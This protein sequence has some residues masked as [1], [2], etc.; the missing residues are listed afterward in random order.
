MVIK[1]LA[2]NAKRQLES[3]TQHPFRHA[4]VHEL[5]AACFGFKSQA[6]LSTDHVLVVFDA[7]LAPSPECL[8]T[9]Q[10]RL[11][12]LGYSSVA[13]TAGTALLQL[14]H[15]LRLGAVPIEAVVRE[16]SGEEWADADWEADD[17]GNPSQ[18]GIDW[19]RIGL[20]ADSLVIAAQRNHAQAH[21]ALA[22]LYRGD[23]LEETEGSEYWHSQMLQGRQLTGIELEWAMA[24]RQQVSDSEREAFHLREAASLGCSEARLELSLCSAYEAEETN[25]FEAAKR[26]YAEAAS[27]GD[28]DAM[29]ALIYTY[30]QSNLFQ[31]WV[32]VYLSELLGS[33][34]RQSTL[35][36]YHDGGMYAGQLYDDDQ[37]GPLY[38][39]GDEG[40]DLASISTEQELEA[41]RVAQQLFSR[42]EG[43]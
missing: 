41:R 13:D 15:E 12:E 35:Q 32:W 17:F 26:S 6:S 7:P 25:D 2:Y 27:L 38:V 24:Y 14:V 20:L 3:A 18:P 36:A 1:E 4:H 9:L 8:A 34:L 40:V 31:N 22:L 42:I 30:D 21:F 11:T 33:D 16:L 23:E 19:E 10:K 43:R 5:L 29:R 37:G 28:V 39:D